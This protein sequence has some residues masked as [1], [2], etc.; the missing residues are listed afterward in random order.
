M[1]KI[2][3]VKTNY[4]NY[5][6]EISEY[7][8]KATTGDSAWSEV[9]DEEYKEIITL[10]TQNKE[11]NRKVYNNGEEYNEYQLFEYIDPKSLLTTLADELKQKARLELEQRKKKEEKQKKRAQT[12]E[13]RRQ[14]K[15]RRRL[16]ELKAKYESGLQDKNAVLVATKY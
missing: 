12:L 13:L 16:A 5:N 14:E 6:E 2:L 8:D 11:S 10:I 1:K 4:S 15:E 3:I 9:S 7:L